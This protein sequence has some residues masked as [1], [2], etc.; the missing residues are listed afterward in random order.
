M[1]K[2]KVLL[3]V[4]NLEIVSNLKGK[5]NITFLFPLTG[6]SIGFKKTFTLEEIKENAYIFVNRIMNNKDIEELKNIL[7]NLPANIN[8]IV[9]DDIGVLNILLELKLPIKKILFQNHVNCNYRSIEAFLEYVDSV[10]VSPDITIPEIEEIL[11][12]APKPLVLYTFGFIP[13]MYSRRTLITNYNEE[14]KKKVGLLANLEEPITKNKLKIIENQEGTVIYPDKPFNAL[15]LKKL[16]N[17]L[18][19]LVNT[20]YLS[21]EE[22]IK[23]IENLTSDTIDT[24]EEIYSYKYLSQEETIVKIKEGQND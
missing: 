14:F 20:T 11:K 5:D 7:K 3:L 4:D 6:F 12:K 10:L 9:F 23:V 8:G 18:F 21:N 15:E 16:K 17:V 2:N 19:F 22:V 1:T 13:I 24:L